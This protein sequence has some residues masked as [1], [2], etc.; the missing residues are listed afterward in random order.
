MGINERREREKEVR[1]DAILDAAENIFFS[2][3][4]DS[5]SMDEIASRAELSKGTLYLYFKNKDELY[6]GIIHR[7]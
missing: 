1:R 5:S 7:G 6:H 4:V 3:G 2:K